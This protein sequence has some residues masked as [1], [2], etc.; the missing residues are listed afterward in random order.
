MVYKVG[1]ASKGANIARGGYGG[2][3][4][5]DSRG[6]GGAVTAE[7]IKGDIVLEVL[8]HPEEVEQGIIMRNGGVEGRCSLF[9]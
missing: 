1:G 8:N 3:I 5:G 4:G 7:G 2:S 9:S 6:R